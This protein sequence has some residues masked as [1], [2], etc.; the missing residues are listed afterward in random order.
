[1]NVFYEEDG[2]FKVGSILTT[3]EAS[4]QVEAAHGKRSRQAGQN[5][6]RFERPSLTE[7]ME[8][9]EAIATDID[10]SFLWECCGSDEFGFEQLAEDYVGHKP[11]PIEAGVA[12]RL[13]SAPM[14]FYRKGKGASRLLQK[15]R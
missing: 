10:T 7:F 4:L 5:G 8:Q 13:H 2:G 1:M 12:M 14:Y 15:K 11:S 9:A 3:T 6:L